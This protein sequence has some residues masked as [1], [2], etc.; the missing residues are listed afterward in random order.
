MGDA[1]RPIELRHRIADRWETD[2]DLVDDLNPARYGV[3]VARTPVTGARVVAQAAMAAR[4]ALPDWSRLPAPARGEILFR[5]GE[6]LAERA[7]A[8]GRELSSEEGKTLSEGV[9][10][11]RRAA[12]IFR[13]AA[14]RTLEPIGSVYASATPGS[15]ITTIRQPIGVVAVITPWNFPIAIPAWKIAPAIAHGN[16]V[17]FKPASATPLLASRLVEALVDAGLPPGVVNLVFAPGAAVTS[18]WIEGGAVDALSFTGSEAVGR[19]LQ[20]LAV[21]RGIKVQLELGGK[22]AVVVDTSADLD[23]AADLIVRGAMASAGQKCT[24]TSRVIPVGGVRGPLLERLVDRVTRL[25]PGDP[26]DPETT[27]G[28]VVDRQAHDRI[29]AT[30]DQAVR[31]GARVAGTSPGDPR[32]SFVPATILDEVAAEMTIAHAEVFGPVLSVIGAPT[33]DAA[34]RTHNQVAYGLSGSIFTRDL[35]AAATFIE[36]ARVGIVHVNGETAGAEPHVPFGGMKASSS[37]S[38]E[39]GHAAD[40]FYTQTK[41]VYVDGL[42]VIGPWDRV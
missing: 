12:A 11:V 24:A 31:D 10:E 3:V 22:N 4:A 28:P 42:P 5:T 27:L 7:D 23:R 15:R 32:G 25:V 13:Y 17:V 1:S 26:L 33:L 14:G 9:G 16:T 37:W 36:A 20:A 19:E 18:A 2:G 6:I 35:E 30:V 29:L 8:L 39:Q 21:A 40:E 41:T 34:I 38:R